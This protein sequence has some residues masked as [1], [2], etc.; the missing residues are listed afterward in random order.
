[1]NG[2]P[3]YKR[4]PRDFFEGTIGMPLEL[5][6][7]YGLVV[8]M[9]YMQNGSLPDDARYIAGNLGCTV[10]QWNSIREKLIS[11]G[12]LVA[13]DGQLAN[14]R[15]DKELVT[16]HSFQEK[17]RENGR[18]HKKIN[19]IDEA[20]AKPKANQSESEQEREERE[21]NGSP[22]KST[23]GSRI[24]PD[25]RLPRSWG[26]ESVEKGLP[27]EI[28]NREAERFKNYWLG[29]PGQKGIKLDWQ[30][31]WRNWIDKRIDEARP[32]SEPQTDFWTGKALA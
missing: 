6:G 12:K 30:A 32:R 4:Y 29:V 3:Y 10:R 27:V 28:V 19:D 23:R 22:K 15:A 1:M 24:Q 31:T 25:W 18:K 20:V 16:S 5:K 7:P 17:Q 26:D 11:L 2:L 9:I 21:P 13:R 14:Y 8:D